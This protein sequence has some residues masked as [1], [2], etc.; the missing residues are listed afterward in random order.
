MNNEAGRIVV[1][2]PCASGKTT[3]VAALKEAGLDAYACA[4]EHSE[5][6]TLWKHYDPAFVVFLDT[7]LRTIRSRR[8]PSWPAMIFRKQ[9]RRLSNARSAADVIID[10]STTDVPT[11]V[12]LVAR[13]IRGDA[14]SG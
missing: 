13:S 1:V 6:P 14:S 9:Q 5:I 7:T 3:L 11:S 8:S 2:G 4:Q 12:E 10:S